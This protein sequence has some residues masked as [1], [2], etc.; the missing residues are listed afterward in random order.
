[1]VDLEE[2]CP[3]EAGTVEGACPVE[4]GTAEVVRP[5][6]AGT[7]EVACPVEAGTA[8]VARPG[9]AGT[10]EVVRP[11]EADTLEVQGG[12]A[13]EEGL[14][15]EDQHLEE[16]LKDFPA[17]STVEENYIPNNSMNLLPDM[18]MCFYCAHNCDIHIKQ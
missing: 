4:A 8:E 10:A 9:E 14:N 5:V 7:A 17:Y 3:V 15:P 18:I 2:A 11:V 13:G 16:E 6:E 12:T 1:M